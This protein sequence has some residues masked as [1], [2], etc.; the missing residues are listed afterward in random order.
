MSKQEAEKFFDNLEKDAK[1]QVNKTGTRKA[2]EKR[3]L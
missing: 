1:L 2:C 3:R